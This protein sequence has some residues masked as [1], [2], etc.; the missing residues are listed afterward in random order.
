MTNLAD[1][2]KHNGLVKISGPKRASYVKNG[3]ID[4]LDNVDENA[5]PSKFVFRE[6]LPYELREVVFLTG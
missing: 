3:E 6:K 4:V 5:D 2:I 1:F